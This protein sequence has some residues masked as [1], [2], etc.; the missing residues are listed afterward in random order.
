MISHPCKISATF[1]TSLHP[2]IHPS[3]IT[4]GY[5]R[6]RDTFCAS[7]SLR[8]THPRITRTPGCI[9]TY[10]RIYTQSRRAVPFTSIN[11]RPCMSC[12][13]LAY[14]YI[15]A[16]IPRRANCSLGIAGTRF[17]RVA[18]LRA[19][20]SLLRRERERE[21]ER[22]RVEYLYLVY[23]MGSR[24]CVRLRRAIAGMAGTCMRVDT[25]VYVYTV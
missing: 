24:R 8:K 2:P 4:N 21:R 13:S 25:C 19:A 17:F 6:L 7:A 3:T 15:R 10:T 11:I 5:R 14:V 12:R 1:P 16:R 18:S 23:S 22:E 20:F 9:Y